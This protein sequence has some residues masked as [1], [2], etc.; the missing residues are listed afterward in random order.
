MFN[1][2]HIENQTPFSITNQPATSFLT[3]KPT[4]TRSITNKRTTPFLITNQPA[5]SFLTTK[6]ITTRSITNKRT[7]SFLITNQPATSP[8]IINQRTTP[9][10]NQT[11]STTA[12]QMMSF[13]ITTILIQTITSNNTDQTT[14][15]PKNTAMLKFQKAS[16]T[17]KIVLF[18]VLICFKPSRMNK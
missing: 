4:T 13:E 7:T 9:F 8:S 6:P 11:R 2:E 18:L 16:I 14:R 17:V 15:G 5:T 3:T 10:S 12:K 1:N